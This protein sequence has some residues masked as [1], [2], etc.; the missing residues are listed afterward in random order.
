M[1]VIATEHL[2]DPLTS[3]FRSAV[4]GAGWQG[5]APAVQRRMARLLTEASPVPF[6]GEIT[7]RRSAVGWV[8]AQLT[9]PFGAPLVPRSAGRCHLSVDIS[10]AD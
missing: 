2:S 6:E 7:C 10:P 8:F 5:L 3:D 1:A 4:G 9:W